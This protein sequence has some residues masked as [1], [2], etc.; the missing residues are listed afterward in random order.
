MSELKPC[1]FCGTTDKVQDNKYAETT[2]CEMC[3]AEIYAS[4][5]NTRP[6]EDALNKRIA[7]LQGEILKAGLRQGNYIK[8]LHASQ[9][10]IAELEAYVEELIEA[11]NALETEAYDAWKKDGMLDFPA[12]ETWLKLVHSK[13]ERE[14]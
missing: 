2:I 3:G 9:D 8:E 13:K 12:A 4:Y 6:I 14:E 11:G 1:P 5:W 10:R 7:E